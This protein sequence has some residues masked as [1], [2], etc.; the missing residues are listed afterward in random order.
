VICTVP[1]RNCPRY[2]NYAFP[3]LTVPE[4]DYIKENKTKR[5]KAK[6]K[7]NMKNLWKIFFWRVVEVSKEKQYVHCGANILCTVV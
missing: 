2:I 3:N 6:G 1:F 7:Y 4:W 5:K